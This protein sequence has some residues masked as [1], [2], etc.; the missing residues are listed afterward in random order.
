MIAGLRDAEQSGN[1]QARSEGRRTCAMLP[2][3]QLGSVSCA[4]SVGCTPAMAQLHV[5]C[6]V[7][8]CAMLQACAPEIST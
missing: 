4:V 7:Q 8:V 1:S 2:M 6:T 5:R 3:C